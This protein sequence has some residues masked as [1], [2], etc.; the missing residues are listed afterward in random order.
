MSNIYK[1]LWLFAAATVLTSCQ[2]QPDEFS[3]D[4]EVSVTYSVAVPNALTTK[5]GAGEFVDHLFWAVY[6]TEEA[7]SSEMDPY[8]DK[9]RLLYAD[10]C[11]FVGG[12]AKPSLKFIKDQNHVVIFWAQHGDADGKYQFPEGDLRK[13]SYKSG[14]INCNDAELEAFYAVD[15]VLDAGGS[16]SKDVVLRRP[17]AQINVGTLVESL[18]ISDTELT[19]KKSSFLV[20]KAP[21]AFSPISGGVSDYAD[22]TFEPSDLIKKNGEYAKFESS[23]REYVQLAMNYVFASPNE[24]ANYDMK[25]TVD[26]DPGSEVVLSIP[27]IPVKGNYRTNITGN[28]LTTNTTYTVTFDQEFAS[29]Y[30]PDVEFLAD[31]LSREGNVYTVTKP[32]GLMWLSGKTLKNSTLQIR[33]D[34]DLGTLE[35]KGIKTEGNV[36]VDG[37]IETDILS[38]SAVITGGMI[39]SPETLFNGTGS[40]SMFYAQPGSELT[41][42]NLKFKGTK[43]RAETNGS[44]YAAVVVGFVQGSVILNNVDVE[45]A[46]VYGEKSSGI[47]T[48][49]VENSGLLNASRCDVTGGSVTVNKYCAGA[50]AG[51][52]YGNAEFVDCIVTSTSFSSE[53]T[54]PDNNDYLGTYIG[55]RRAECK[56]CL[57]GTSVQNGEETV[58]SYV[59][60]VDVTATPS[61]VIGHL[62]SGSKA[63]LALA[64][65]TYDSFVTPANGL[66][67]SF[68]PFAGA[69]PSVK[70]ISVKD[71]VSI[72]GLTFTD[73]DCAVTVDSVDGKYITLVNNTINSTYGMKIT[74]LSKSLTLYIDGNTAAKYSYSSEV[75]WKSCTNIKG[76]TFEQIY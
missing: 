48:G 51:R 12:Q 52:V 34:I 10:K 59:E 31:G 64:D 38:R 43:V 65:G 45:N 35:F 54:D 68:I 27:N 32:E 28:L 40:A 15:F 56:S 46:E 53:D 75:D 19:L 8:S 5:A 21:T 63:T 71:N 76:I 41:V 66:T 62:A 6:V 37:S 30:Q 9:T 11:S 24:S 16:P 2:K 33:A 29:D 50:L 26:T 22:L 73:T 18:K 70:S 55:Q 23:S 20:K 58:V 3:T 25:L 17:V 69:T 42:R 4:A 61:V 44:G 7:P 57:F 36:V 67:L 1:Y 13:V 47:L 14:T 72:E 60:Y 39:V 74:G 49:F